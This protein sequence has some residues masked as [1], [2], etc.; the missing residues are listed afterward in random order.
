[1]SSRRGGFIAES[2]LIRDLRASSLVD[3]L[4]EVVGVLAVDLAADRLRGAKD[5]EDGALELLGE[6]ARAH[7]ARDA[8]G[9]GVRKARAAA[10]GDELA[11]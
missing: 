3:L 10:R 2:L 4:D 8:L 1:M 9:L 5:L 11:D 7:D 6:R